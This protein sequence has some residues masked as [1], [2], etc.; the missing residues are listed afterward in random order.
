MKLYF[1]GNIAPYREKQLIKTKAH[2]LFSFYYHGE[3]AEF[4]GEFQLRI[5][6]EDLLSRNTRGEFSE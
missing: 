2:R 4:R 1:A 3:K 6:H 5:E